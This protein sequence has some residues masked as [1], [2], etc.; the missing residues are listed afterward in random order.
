MTQQRV[1]PVSITSVLPATVTLSV[2]G[3]LGQSAN[4]VE[5]KTGTGATRAIINSFGSLQMGTINNAGAWINVQPAGTTDIGIIVRGA[6]SQT[7]NLQEWQESGAQPRAYI[8]ALGFLRIRTSDTSSASIVAG[9]ASTTQTPLIVEGLASQTG[10]L[11]IWRNSAASVI[12]RVTASGAVGSAV[13]FTN[14]GNTG[15]YLDTTTNQM[16]VIQRVAATVAFAVRGAASQSA[17][18]TRCRSGV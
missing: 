10:D 2:Q 14:S 13:G 16:T 6:A 9:P 15:S 3:A 18:P 12:A 4:L 5:F 1:S 11:Q 17:T 7:G 8:T